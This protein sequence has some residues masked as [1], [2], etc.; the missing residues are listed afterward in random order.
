LNRFE[1]IVFA[2]MS[3]PRRWSPIPGQ[4]SL[5]GMHQSIWGR[6]GVAMCPLGV[7][8]RRQSCVLGGFDPLA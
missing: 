5:R 1:R 6:C 4:T 2:A 7:T 3:T 8:D